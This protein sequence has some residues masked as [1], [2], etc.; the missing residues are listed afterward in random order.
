MS[1]Q[2]TDAQ[3]ETYKP[4]LTVAAPDTLSSGLARNS[5]FALNR[6]CFVRSQVDVDQW[7]CGCMNG[8]SLT[9]QWRYVKV[10]LED[11]CAVHYLSE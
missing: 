1:E 5:Q 8:G 9:V 6:Y 11:S 3:V 7:I 4:K 10:G 2:L